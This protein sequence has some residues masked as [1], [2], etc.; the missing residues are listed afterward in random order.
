MHRNRLSNHPN[1]VR[2][3]PILIENPK[4]RPTSDR[5]RKNPDFDIKCHYSSWKRAVAANKLTE[6]L[7]ELKIKAIEFQMADKEVIPEEDD[8][9]AFW[10]AL[11]TYFHLLNLVRAL[12][13]RTLF[14]DGLGNWQGGTEPPEPQYHWVST[15]FE[16]NCRW[17]MPWLQTLNRT[18]KD[19][20]IS[21]STV[22]W[23]AWQLL[24]L[25]K[26]KVVKNN[27]TANPV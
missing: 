23:K 6:K 27:K 4:S 22:Q 17:Q 20:Q 24:L 12:W 19:I 5:D 18:I 21:W 26:V 3:T 14:F 10:S 7:Q 8:I 9:N 16:T 25:H 11:H 13:Q 2:I 1:F 15:V